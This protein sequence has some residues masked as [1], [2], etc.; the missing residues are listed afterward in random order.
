M[1]FDKN[2]LV[3]IKN[4]IKNHSFLITSFQKFLKKSEHLKL[5]R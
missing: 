2:L 4:F 1:T 5:D 3:K